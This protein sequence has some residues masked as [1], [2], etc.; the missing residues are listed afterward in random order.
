MEIVK[1]VSDTVDIMDA[2]IL[3][4]GGR[5]MGNAEN[6]K[7]LDDLAEQSK[8]YCFA[9]SSARSFSVRAGTILFRSPTIP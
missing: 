1:A 7:M 9:A 5:G 8:L 6:F 3:V 4:S 2:K